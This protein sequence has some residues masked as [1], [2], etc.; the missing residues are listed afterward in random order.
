MTYQSKV[1]PGPT[2]VRYPDR[3][4]LIRGN[5]ESR[6]ITQVYGFYDECLRKYGSVTVWRYC[7]EIFDYLSLSAIIDGKVSSV[8]FRRIRRKTCVYLQWSENLPWSL[9]QRGLASLIR[10]LIKFRLILFIIDS[11]KQAGGTNVNAKPFP[12]IDTCASQNYKPFQIK[13]KG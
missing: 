2:Q 9:E 4:T 8:D 10:G 12:G 6:Q 11:T 13:K 3:I 7:T 1:C 5:H